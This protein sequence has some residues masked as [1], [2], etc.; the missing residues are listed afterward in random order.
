MIKSAIKASL[1]ILVIAFFS[2]LSFLLGYHF[3]LTGIPLPY[4][5]SV[6]LPPVVNE[7]INQLE[8]KYYAPV[9]KQKLINGAING[10]VEALGNPYAQYL[11]PKTYNSFQTSMSGNY[12]GVG[13]SIGGKKG[14]VRILTV[15]ENSPAAK[16]GLMKDDRITKIDEKSAAS[17]APDTASALIKGKSGTKVRLTVKR[18]EVIKTFLL[19]RK[20]IEFP[21]ATSRMET[22]SIG[23]VRLHSFTDNASSEVA[24][25]V[26]KLRK[27]GAKAIVFDLRGNPGG[28]LTEAVNVSSLF[29]KNGMILKT[30]DRTKN[31]KTYN[32]T[33]KFVFGGP[34]VL[35]VDQDSASASEIVSGALKD[36]HRAKLVGTKTFGKG[37]VQSVTILSNGGAILIPTQYWLTP[38]GTN[39]SK[40]GITP[41]IVIKETSQ[42][43]PRAL[44][45]L[46]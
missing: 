7:A 32:A 4:T 26:N 25:E 31:E 46:R 42:Q 18:K 13:M 40:K 14:N 33:G 30:Q 41:D 3:Y 43:L 6:T 27:K 24:R 38:D 15:F 23:Y 20:T 22:S 45:L 2:A 8:Y 1:L 44:Q 12:S 37:T 34:L 17:M 10:I 11:D 16:A 19:I 9:N 36:H 21:N 35:L 28:E 39:I 29:I 5:S